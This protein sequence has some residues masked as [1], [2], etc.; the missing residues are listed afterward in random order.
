MRLLIDSANLIEVGLSVVGDWVGISPT[1][2]QRSTLS[3]IMNAIH[4]ARGGD[5]RSQ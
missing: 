1:E 4:N 5:L 2:K 3:D